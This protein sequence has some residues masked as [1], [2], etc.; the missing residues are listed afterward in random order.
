MAVRTAL[1]RFYLKAYEDNITGLAAMVAYNLLLSIFP[2]AL[3]A[4][5]I[6]SQVLSSPQL[7]TS[8]F[9]DLQQLFP[10]AAESTLVNLLNQIRTST[11]GLGLVALV[12]SIW[13]CTSFWGALDTAFAR[14]YHTIESRKWVQQKRFALAMLLV[15]LLFIAATVAVPALQSILVDGAADLPLGLGGI[16]AVVYA[17]SLAG[18]VLL[19]FLILTIIYRRVPY[20]RMAWHAVW[21]GALGAT[22]AI[23]LVDY[24]FPAYLSSI[25]TLAGLGTTLI[26]I[27][28]VLL[29]FYVVAIII[30]GGAVINSMRHEDGPPAHRPRGLLARRRAGAMV[31]IVREPESESKPGEGTRSKQ[32][33]DVVM[34]RAEL[35][36]IWTPMYLERLAATYWRF[37]ERVSLHL[38]HVAYGPDSRAVKFLF[39]PL[40]TFH[41]PEYETH[42]DVGTVTWR[43]N[44]GV[45]VAPGG[46]GQG[47]LRI[48]AA[49]PPA[50]ESREA[51]KSA[52]G[53]SEEQA[54]VRVSSEVVNFYPLL[55]GWGWAARIFR[56]LYRATQL[57]IHV[58]VTHAFLRSLARM[59]L[60]ESKV[61][62]LLPPPMDPPRLP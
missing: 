43:I 25:S 23:T 2:L 22:L 6:T 62:A 4:L 11:T 26:F 5:F 20:E 47:Y 55:A 39:F 49:R 15:S 17:I 13:I 41:A 60:A 21:P 14:I 57:R 50:E 24:A 19:L 16:H 33:A 58:I 9:Q 59:D 29:W 36:R 7:Q 38:L 51:V 48:T 8:I 10:N 54:T 28:I 30:L 37:L 32:V 3:I 35:D 40:L 56:H 61:G 12:A 42:A 31:Q 53:P 52:P 44:R 27:V 18:G 45:L 34:P 1:K 46:R